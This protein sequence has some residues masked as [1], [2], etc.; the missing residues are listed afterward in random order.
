MPHQTLL[1]Q[2]PTAPSLRKREQSANHAHTASGSI[3]QA[4]RSTSCPASFAGGTECIRPEVVPADAGCGL[5]RD[6]SF[7]RCTAAV[8][9]ASNGWRL[10]SE[11]GGQ[12]GLA[13]SS[14]RTGE[15]VMSSIRALLGSFPAMPL[16]AEVAPRSVLTGRIR[17]G[18][19]PRLRRSYRRRKYG[20]LH[21]IGLGSVEFSCHFSHLQKDLAERVGF[22]PT[23]GMT[24]RRFSRPVP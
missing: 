9:P 10:N 24:L 8:V 15:Y 16:N 2:P 20:T 23:E 21:G 12:A 14:R 6:A 3:G 18:Y 17:I 1:S 13:T 5:D 19:G 4:A 7:R 11:D 22:E